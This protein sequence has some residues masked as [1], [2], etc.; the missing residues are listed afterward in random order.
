MSNT[1]Q[2][3]WILRADEDTGPGPAQ[4]DRRF[5]QGSII[6]A[7]RVCPPEAW[8]YGADTDLL[9]ELATFVDRLR[10]VGILRPYS[11][12]PP[13]PLPRAGA[14]DPAQAQA[15]PSGSRP[16]LRAVPSRVVGGEF[17]AVHHITV[18]CPM[19]RGK[20]S[21]ASGDGVNVPDGAMVLHS[22][23]PC[24]WFLDAPDD[25]AFWVPYF[26]AGV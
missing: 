4:P 25:T 17:Q 15:S 20:I 11:P 10:D 1:A 13:L 3:I 9:E 19:C 14:A 12:Q 18:K 22:M 5:P 24:Q 21:A 7:A 2:E 6:G 8:S 26:V 16:K 23:E